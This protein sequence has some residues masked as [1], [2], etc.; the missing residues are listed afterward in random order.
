MAEH[1]W[2]RV[3]ALRAAFTRFCDRSP[4][5]ESDPDHGSTQESYA[6]WKALNTEIWLRHHGLA[7]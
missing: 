6:F 5:A 7:G 1:G 4:Q 2:F 3:P